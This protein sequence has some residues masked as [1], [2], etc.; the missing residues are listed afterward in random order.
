MCNPS[1]DRN[2]DTTHDQRF[3]GACRESFVML[4]PFGSEHEHMFFRTPTSRSFDE[5]NQEAWQVQKDGLVNVIRDMVG[6]LNESPKAEFALGSLPG[7]QHTIAF[8]RRAGRACN[9]TLYSRSASGRIESDGWSLVFELMSFPLPPPLACGAQ[10]TTLIPASG[11]C[12]WFPPK[13]PLGF[14]PKH[15]TRVGKS[16]GH[17]FCRVWAVSS[18]G[19]FESRRI[20]RPVSS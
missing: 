4:R 5:S 16:R 19:E 6:L 18:I 17:S 1:L 2:V 7:P 12:A 3:D 14:H 11:Q 10:R 15:S 9:Y 20:P 13:V 8:G